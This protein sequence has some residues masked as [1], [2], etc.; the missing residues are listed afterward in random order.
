MKANIKGI[1]KNEY[2]NFFPV[3]INNN[4]SEL[5]ITLISLKFLKIKITAITIVITTNKILIISENLLFIKLV[6]I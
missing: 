2:K 1:D 4:E 5:F 6:K 3:G